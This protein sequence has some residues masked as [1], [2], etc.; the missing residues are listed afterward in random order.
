MT[1]LLIARME[2]LVG[3]MTKPSQDG[4]ILYSRE[5]AA[6]KLSISVP[7]LDK[8]RAARKIVAR[9]QG[10]K[11]LFHIDELHRYARTLPADIPQ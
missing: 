5:G 9:K 8:L 11:V 3:Q 4:P 7:E 1:D 6:A 2:E 10:R